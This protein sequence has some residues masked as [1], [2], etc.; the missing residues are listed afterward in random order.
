MLDSLP[1]KTQEDENFATIFC[2]MDYSVLDPLLNPPEE[3]NDILSLSI[4]FDFDV[5]QVSKYENN[6]A[7]AAL[8]SLFSSS[9]DFVIV[10]VGSEDEDE[11]SDGKKKVQTGDAAKKSRCARDSSRGKKCSVKQPVKAT[12]FAPIFP[13]CLALR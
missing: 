7:C 2:G 12:D 5:A 9:K 13:I 3:I 4:G 11:D 10:S 1:L 6:V 8:D